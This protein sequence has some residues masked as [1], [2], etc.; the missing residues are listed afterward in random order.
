MDHRWADLARTLRHLGT[1]EHLS[2]DAAAE[3][4]RM[5]AEGR[6]SILANDEDEGFRW[7]HVDGEEMAE[8]G[9]ERVLRRLAPG[10][11]TRGIEL[12]VETVDRPV[13]VQDGDYV[14][15]INGRRCVV[16][17][18]ED[19][20]TG[21][22]WVVSTV[23]PLAVVNDLLAESGVTSRLFT[24]TAGANEGIAWLVDPRIVAAIVDSGLVNEPSLPVLA[25]YEDQF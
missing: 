25:A 8:G 22:A 17:R 13:G 1:W 18:P 2:E 10:L 19:W 23:R 15:E 12:Q 24:L 14:V 21:R 3:A 6:L 20:S 4:E 5:A 9:V 11:R 16:W 7:F